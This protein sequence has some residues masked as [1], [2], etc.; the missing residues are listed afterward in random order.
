M[1]TTKQVLVA[2]S[3]S[4][5]VLIFGLVFSAAIGGLV[6]FA[7]TQ[8]T[9]AVRTDTFE[10]ALTIAQSG[11]EYYRWHLAHDIDDFTDGTGQLGGSYVHQIADPYGETEGVFSLTVDP[12]ATGSTIISI[13]SQGW[14]ASA[15]DIKRTVKARYGIPSWATY[16]FLHNANIWFG[17][18]ITVH[19][20]IRSNGGIRMDG[21]HDSLVESAKETYTCG[22]ETGCNTPQ[23]RPGIWGNGGPT[24]LWNFPVTSLDFNS[25][26][27][28]FSSMRTYAQNDGLYLPATTDYGYHIIFAANGTFEVRQ[29]T[30]ANGI[31]GWS[32]EDGC[33][34]LYQTIVTEQSV[35]TYSVA[36][37][38]IIFAEDTLWVEG[39]LNGKTS[40]VA[41]RFP[42]DVNAMNIWIPNNLTY[43]A[44]DGTSGL[45]LIAQQDIIFGYAVPTNFEVDAALL[46]KNGK[47]IRHHYNYPQCH[48]GPF[49]IRQQLTVYGAL[50][51]NQKS[52]WTFGSGNPVSGFINRDI[53]YDT[54]LY[55]FP[56]PFFPTQGEYEFISW[57]EE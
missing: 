20:R 5:L 35:G 3:I 46:A 23:T 9:S 56:P 37:T 32:V 12:P 36:N 43:V 7:A 40:V 22:T 41:A 44:K 51:S 54:S 28:D 4:I 42:I 10:R 29:V 2:G 48:G 52:Y 30:R 45:G 39:V 27:L 38:P 33:Q 1:K 55:F 49:A 47:V 18:G 53:T 34:T 57:E 11:A 26:S 6:L 13:T 16:A 21:T 50:I 24:E 15:P 19:G 25:L 17:S 31:R 8:Y 14:L